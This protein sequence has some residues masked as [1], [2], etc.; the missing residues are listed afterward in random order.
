MTALTDSS[1]SNGAGDAQQRFLEQMTAELHSIEEERQKLRSGIEE[2]QAQLATLDADHA[3]RSRVVADARRTT[4]ASQ[5]QGPTAAAR[6]HSDAGAEKRSADAPSDDRSGP[7]VAERGADPEPAETAGQLAPAEEGSTTPARA[8]ASKPRTATAS[9]RSATPSRG[10]EPTLVARMRELIDRQTEP[11]T[12]AECAQ[13]LGVGTE[14]ARAALNGLLR[15]GRVTRRQ[16]QRTVYYDAVRPDDASEGAEPANSAANTAPD[17]SDSA[18][19]APG[20]TRK[21]G[22]RRRGAQETA[23]AGLPAGTAVPTVSDRV[24]QVL[25]AHHEPQSVD[26]I[27]VQVHGTDAD[28]KAINGTRTALDRL[29][30]RKAAEKIHLGRRRVAYQAADGSGPGGSGLSVESAPGSAPK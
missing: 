8:K 3:V 23:A 10:T 21:T 13:E 5:D 22:T 28:A 17:A 15:V 14:Q 24:H 19:A 9:R 25:Q 20:Q 18:A 2:M 16:Q 4:G 26:Q 12:A 7:S 6:R 29:V 27:A 1:T 30:A 11:R